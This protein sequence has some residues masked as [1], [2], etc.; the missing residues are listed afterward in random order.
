MEPKPANEKFTEFSTTAMLKS[1]PQELARLEEI[2]ER[3]RAK[4]NERALA[5]LAIHDRQLYLSEYGSFRDYL[6]KR[7]QIKP[8][9][10]Y[11]LLRWARLLMA[12]TGA[13][14]GGPQNERQSRRLDAEGKTRKQGALDWTMRAMAYLVKVWETVAPAERRDFIH[15]LQSLLTEMAQ[16]LEPTVSSSHQLIAAVETVAVNSNQ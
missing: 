8:S 2:V 3:A 13:Q 7:W 15:A 4:P 10:G 9:R 14:P 1:L 6:W 5:L 11:Q 16:E 12:P